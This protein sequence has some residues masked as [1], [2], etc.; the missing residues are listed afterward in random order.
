MPFQ[1]WAL[2]SS[3]DRKW[4]GQQSWE[5][6]ARVTP[7]GGSCPAGEAVPRWALTLPE[8]PMVP[9][10]HLGQGSPFSPYCTLFLC[11]AKC[12][13][14]GCDL[15]RELSCGPQ[16]PSLQNWRSTL[17][18]GCG[19]GRVTRRNRVRSADTMDLATSPWRLAWWA[20][21]QSSRVKA[22]TPPCSLLRP[23]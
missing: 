14:G 20:S 12:P 10:G 4:K 23:L 13:G 8:D 5:R 18:G 19:G 11:T 21:Q 16:G 6:R 22:R 9:G 7:N 17:M 3:C 1:N 2:C 15:P